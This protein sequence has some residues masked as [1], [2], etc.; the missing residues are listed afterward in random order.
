MSP[1]VWSTHGGVREFIELDTISQSG[2][3][4]HMR[5]H[6]CVVRSNMRS[7][8][9]SAIPAKLSFHPQASN[10]SS[11]TNIAS[12]NASNNLGTSFAFGEHDSPDILAEDMTTCGPTGII[13]LSHLINSHT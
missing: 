2:V 12:T 8:M 4:P 11:I 9:R 6:N 3:S 10:V 1:H 5:S 7:N 13:D